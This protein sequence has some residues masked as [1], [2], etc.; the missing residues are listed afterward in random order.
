MAPSMNM[1][2]PI[3]AA[4]GGGELPHAGPELHTLLW[5]WGIFFLLLVI[6]WKTAWKPL[7]AAIEARE[8]RIAD[9]LEKAEEVQRAAAAIAEKQAAL[10]A[11][12]QAQAKTVLDGARAD[13]DEYR[14]K[15]H[16]KAHEE[17]TDFLA[18]AKKEIA[19][20][21]NKARDALRREV[22]DLTLLAA[23]RVLQ[24]S[25][26]GEDEKRMAAEMVTELQKRQVGVAR[27]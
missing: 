15:E 18:R 7:L 16:A 20:E 17:A 23:S 8:K 26:S 5:V 3:L 21:E 27:N 12:A 19:L 9:S 10:L 6:L 2:V 24:R 25:L 13:A 1:L 14:K 22:V 4:G 11:E